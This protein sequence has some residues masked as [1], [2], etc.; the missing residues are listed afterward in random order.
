MKINF[1]I[2][3]DVTDEVK[4]DIELSQEELEE[5]AMEIEEII[6]ESS[7]IGL[8]GKYSSVMLSRIEVAFQYYVKYYE[9]DCWN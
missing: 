3:A 8:V 2:T 9:N 5:L 6:T 1:L 4:G 7:Q